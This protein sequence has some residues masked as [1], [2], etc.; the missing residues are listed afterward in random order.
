MP[1]RLEQ[2]EDTLALHQPADKKNLRRR[3]RRSQPHARHV[4]DR[5]LA[6]QALRLDAVT[7]ELLTH[8]RRGRDDPVRPS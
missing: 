5:Q 3:Q 4:D 1:G 6:H 8:D 7:L 2:V